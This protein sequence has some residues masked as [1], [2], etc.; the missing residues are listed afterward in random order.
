[1]FTN[2][3]KEKENCENNPETVQTAASHQNWWET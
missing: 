3:Q 2:A 1:M